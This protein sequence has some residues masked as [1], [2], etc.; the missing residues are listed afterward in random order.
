MVPWQGMVLLWSRRHVDSAAA[1][2]A[3]AA[4]ATIAMSSMTTGGL[5]KVGGVHRFLIEPGLIQPPGSSARLPVRCWPSTGP[6]FSLL[7]AC[8]V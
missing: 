4:A 3:A 5:G 7:Y 1:A 2:A 8:M 6:A